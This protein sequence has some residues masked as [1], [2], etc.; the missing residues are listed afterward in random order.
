[1]QAQITAANGAAIRDQGKRIVF[2]TIDGEKNAKTR[3]ARFR[4]VSRP[5]MAIADLLDRG[6][7]VVLERDASGRNVSGIYDKNGTKIPIN[8]R[9]RTFE[10]SM[11]IGQQPASYGGPGRRS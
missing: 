10:V 1:M 6:Q 4:V 3:G 2:G 9:R 8:E 5:L 7:K 11:T